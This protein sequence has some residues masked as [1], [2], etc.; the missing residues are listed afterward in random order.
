MSEKPACFV[1][2]DVSKAHLDVG[3][4]GQDEVERFAN[5][6]GGREQCARR[7][8]EWDP[9][10][11]VME[12]TG[13]LEG[14]LAALLVVKGVEVSIVNPR[15]V[16]DFAKA[17]GVLAKT[18]AVDARVLAR[19][20]AA[21]RPE[22]RALKDEELALLDAMLTR[23]R[24]ILEMIVA[25]RNRLAGAPPKKVARTIREHIDWL[26][27]QLKHTNNDI[28]GQIRESPVWR[29]RVELMTSVTGV[30]QITAF[31]LLA[32]LPELGLLDG[33]K[34]SALSGVC[35]YNRD[36]G[37]RYG[38][39]MI[40]GGRGTVRA[41]LYMAALVASR[42]NPVIRAFYERLLAAGKPKKVALTACMRK[43]LLILNAIVR[44]G[45][46]WNPALASH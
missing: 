15:Q 19:F 8:K 42:H 36:S 33:R 31:T 12:A 20:A 34:I 3:R 4:E 38:K 28:D 43:L 39:R 10:L 26:R 6:E 35:P 16:R 5:D 29:D 11:V 46:P 27:R 41:A 30:G 13:G 7:L 40:H 22:P 25:E 1:G 37:R 32:D 9:A 17:T 45:H 18:D 24:Q 14:S 2:I 44:T 23:R 21:I